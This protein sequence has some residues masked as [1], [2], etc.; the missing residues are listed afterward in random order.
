MQ[1]V[2]LPIRRQQH[3]IVSRVVP[4]RRTLAW[5]WGSRAQKWQKAHLTL[6]LAVLNSGKSLE[7]CSSSLG[8]LYI[9][10]YIPAVGHC[11]SDSQDHCC[12]GK[13]LKVEMKDFHAA[14]EDGSMSHSLNSLKGVIGDYYRGY[15]GD[16]T[17]IAHMIQDFGGVSV[18]EI[19]I[20]AVCR[21]WKRWL[22]HRG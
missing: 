12:E 15:S 21:A 2:S 13:G 6:D 4:C 5:L 16:T 9:Y 7:Q 14:V 11:Q 20:E 19:H 3:G 18:R 1:L 10:I 22:Q 17:T 8:Y